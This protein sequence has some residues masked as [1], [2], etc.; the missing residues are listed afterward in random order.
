MIDQDT[1]PSSARDNSLAKRIQS[2]NKQMKQAAIGPLL[3]AADVMDVVGRW[4]QFREEAGFD[5]PSE[6]LTHVFRRGLGV[7]FWKARAE[8]VAALGKDGDR[9]IVRAL[10]HDAAVWIY[11]SVEPEVHEKL[12]A[13]VFIQYRDQGSPLSRGQA[14]NL[15]R[16]MVGAAPR[17]RKECAS[18]EKLRAL[19]KKHGIEG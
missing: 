3:V 13:E 15:Y 18:C 7:S 12:L 19:L 9:S 4:S 17:T 2:W 10:H 11:K 1:A 16:R 14:M 6:W 8:A 5:T